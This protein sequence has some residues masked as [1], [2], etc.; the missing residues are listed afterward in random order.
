M[1]RIVQ[2][3][4]DWLLLWALRKGEVSRADGIIL[5]D[6]SGHGA[7]DLFRD[8]IRSALGL[9]QRHDRRRYAR[10]K[11]TVNWIAN[12]VTN[13]VGAGYDFRHR[14]LDIDFDSY[15]RAAP[16]RDTLEAGCACVIVSGATDGMIA[17]RGIDYQANRVRI[18]RLCHVEMNRFAA[19]L[20]AFDS[21]RYRID[22]LH[23][24]YRES[25]YEWEHTASPIRKKVSYIAR[26]SRSMR[27]EP[28]PAPNGGPTSHSANSGAGGGPPSVS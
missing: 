17:L 12:R 22:L 10:V 1:A 11:S 23:V 24:E 28:L 5:T 13:T 16:D 6:V 2:K 14:T 25:D 19:R 20:A 4:S 18:D 7:P 27:A 9:I 15:A 26:I 8:T 3:F 21:N